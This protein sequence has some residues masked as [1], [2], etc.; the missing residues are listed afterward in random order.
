MSLLSGIPF[1]PSMESVAVTIDE[2]C[3]LQLPKGTL[4]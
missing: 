2:S 3:S 1:N 4:D